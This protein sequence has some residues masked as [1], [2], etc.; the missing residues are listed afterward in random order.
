MEALDGSVSLVL[1]C[2]REWSG[3]RERE[4]EGERGNMGQSSG[5]ETI[6]HLVSVSLLLFDESM[7]GLDA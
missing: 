4:N 7:V 6:L 5:G 2:M 3:E 1:Y